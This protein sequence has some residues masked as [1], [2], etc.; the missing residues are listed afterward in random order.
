MSGLLGCTINGK[1]MFGGSED[2]EPAPEA[3]QSSAYTPGSTEP[4][5]ESVPSVL[6]REVECPSDMGLKLGKRK[7]DT[8]VRPTVKGNPRR[9]FAAE[10]KQPA[11]ESFLLSNEDA[12]NQVIALE[13]KRPG[14]IPAGFRERVA[15]DPRSAELRIEM[16]L[17]ELQS[18]E[19]RRRA[20]HD[21]AMAVL[22]G[23]EE[24]ASME[25]LE[26]TLKPGQKTS[27]GCTRG[28]CDEGQTCDPKHKTCE[29]S[30]TRALRWISAAELDVE[31]ILTRAFVRQVV[32]SGD[33]KHPLLPWGKTRRHRCGNGKAIC[34][35]TDYERS[36]G[37]V[38]F[39]H[40]DLREGGTSM[41]FNEEQADWF[42]KH[43]KP[44]SHT[45]CDE[46][47]PW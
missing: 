28:P 36:G 34:K 29:T 44:G 16:A 9:K 13:K 31:H 23:A 19:T 4:V 39:V 14:L 7:T 5:E 26:E 47:Q 18:D 43:C 35:F 27:S 24:A 40:W 12:V 15:K 2:P 37:R 38:D 42:R 25:L 22:L 32:E 33:P 41:G 8:R 21:A 20:S 45:E 11:A 6:E 46:E 10:H 17:C 1:P 30:T 3:S